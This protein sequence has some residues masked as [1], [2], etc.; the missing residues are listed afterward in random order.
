MVIGSMRGHSQRQPVAIAYRHDFHAFS[1]P[2][3][4]NLLA[5]TLGDAKQAS[6]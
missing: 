6:M 1:A 2:T 4:P 3:R 5:A